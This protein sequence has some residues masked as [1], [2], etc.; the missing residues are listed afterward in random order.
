MKTKTKILGLV[1]ARAGSVGLK[2]KN[3]LKIN[4]KTLVEYAIDVGLKSKR[5]TKVLVSTDSKK[6]VAISKKKKI[7]YVKR[8]YK[9]S[10]SNAKI[11]DVI[12]HAIR[13]LKKKKEFY[14][15]VVCLQPTT[16]LKNSKMIDN[17]ILK[18]INDRSDS[19]VS[20]YKVEDNH[21]SRMYKI[22]KNNLFPVDKKTQSLNRQKL[23]DI[24]HR[25]GNVY[26]FKVAS[27]ERNK[28]LYSSKIS[29]MILDVKYKLNI[30]TRL[31]FKLAKLILEK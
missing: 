3:I 23:T 22:K 16:P 31:D 17:G 30:D 21:P 19:L 18:I 1:P 8:P 14:E 11:L 2:N 6:I 24:Y 25:D 13:K 27:L 20:V 15:Y 7:S 5:I 26:I 4:G 29:P 10:G 9:F 28:S 12:L